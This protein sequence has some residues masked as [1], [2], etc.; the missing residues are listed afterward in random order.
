VAEH[1]EQF[2][3]FSYGVVGD[4][5][6]AVQRRADAPALA[7]PADM[8][9]I[10]HDILQQAGQR[11]LE[12]MTSSA[13]PI[14][15]RLRQDEEAS[16][17]GAAPLD[18]Q[19]HPAEE[20]PQRPGCHG[21]A[22]GPPNIATTESEDTGSSLTTA[23]DISSPTLPKTP[24]GISAMEHHRRQS[25]TFVSQ[26]QSLP[27]QCLETSCENV[28]LHHQTG[29]CFGPPPQLP[30]DFDFDWD[31]EFDQMMKFSTDEWDD[32]LLFDGASFGRA[33]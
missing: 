18:R 22:G 19:S 14:L 33:D 6:A 3:R 11:Y 25:I 23:S 10:Y 17:S 31:T 9:S 15:G 30:G 13:M 8:I 27:S 5:W 20:C 21:T 7:D 2:L 32:S 4:L 28:S 12:R 26:V 29:N 16:V 1:L 24:Q